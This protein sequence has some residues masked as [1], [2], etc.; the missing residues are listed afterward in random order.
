MPYGVVA[1]L[2]VSAATGLFK[3]LGKFF[4]SPGGSAV[5]NLAGNVIGAGLQSR[6]TNRAADLA[7]LYNTQ[8]LDFLKSQDAR[9]FAEYLKE[10]DR[11]WGL[12]DQDRGRAEEMRQL[13]MLRDR[14]REG[15]L[16]P[17]RQNA[18]QGY[19]TLSSLLFNADQPMAMPPPVSGATTRRLSDLMR[20]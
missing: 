12:Q 9:D 13:A 20:G 4:G 11:N 18:A 10:R 16:V 15:R 7:S 19:E 5:T 6:G 8:A 2:A 17:F 3:T 14:E 1:P